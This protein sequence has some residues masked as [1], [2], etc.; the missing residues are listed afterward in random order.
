MLN[1]SELL[2]QC[3]NIV[4]CRYQDQQDWIKFQEVEEILAEP[5]FKQV[6]VSTPRED[7]CPSVPVG[8]LVEDSKCRVCFEDFDQFYHQEKEEW[9]LKNAV[10]L[11]G[12]TFH[13]SCYPDF[14]NSA[15]DKKLMDFND[16]VK[17]Q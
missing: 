7:E 12:I 17:D 1:C 16:K 11:D 5:V 6:K 13:T 4:Y 3:I 14:A 10:R 15:C 2:G 9:H 8:S